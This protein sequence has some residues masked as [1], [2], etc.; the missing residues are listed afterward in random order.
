MLILVLFILLFVLR[1]FGFVCS[2]SYLEGLRYVIVALPG[3]SLTFF[4]SVCICMDPIHLYG[5]NVDNF[6][7]LLL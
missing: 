7:H 4:A 6:K 5:K 3:L 2:S 1:L